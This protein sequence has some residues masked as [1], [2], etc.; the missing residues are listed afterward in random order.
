[1]SIMTLFSNST[2][3]KFTTKTYHFVRWLQSDHIWRNFT[4]LAKVTSLWQIFDG[5]FLFWQNDETTLAICDIVGQI[6]ITENG[7]ILKKQS[8]QS[9]HTGWLPHRRRN[10]DGAL[11]LV[12]ISRR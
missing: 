10:F 1:M 11:K 12:S 5:L 3:Y 6:F 7:Q 8:G 2:T 9:G 4:T